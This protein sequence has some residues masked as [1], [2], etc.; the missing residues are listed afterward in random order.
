MQKG[1]SYEEIS[2]VA[3]LLHGLDETVA[4]KFFVQHLLESGLDNNKHNEAI[5]IIL[6]VSE[7]LC[8]D[9]LFDLADIFLIRAK[10]LYKID[11][12]AFWLSV[13]SNSSGEFLHFLAHQLRR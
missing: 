4:T 11:F 3:N 7:K 2:V 1:G 9:E 8:I 5:A 10:L 13:G 12:D 6:K